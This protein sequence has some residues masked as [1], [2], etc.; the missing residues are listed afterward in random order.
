MPRVPPPSLLPTPCINSCKNPG[1]LSPPSKGTIPPT[2]EEATGTHTEGEGQRASAVPRCVADMTRPHVERGHVGPTWPRTMLALVLGMGVVLWMGAT[3]KNGSVDRQRRTMR[4]EQWNQA[5]AVTQA[6]VR[7]AVLAQQRLGAQGRD[8]WREKTQAKWNPKHRDPKQ[9]NRIHAVAEENTQ[10]AAAS[11]DPAQKTSQ[12]ETQGKER[13]N[14]PEEEQEADMQKFI[15]NVEHPKIMRDC[16]PGSSDPF[17]IHPEE[18]RV[19]LTTSVGG[20][21]CLAIFSGAYIMAIQEEKLGPHFRKSAPMTAAAGLIWMTVATSYKINSPEKI[22][23][24]AAVARHELL[25]FGEVFLFLLVAMT[26]VNTMQEL[27]VFG[28]LRVFLVEKEYSLKTMFWVTGL[29][30][31]FLSPLADNLTTALLMGAVINTVGRG[32]PNFVVLG[33][34]NTVVASNAG[35]AFSPFGDVT[36]LMVWQKHKLDIP[37]FVELLLPSFVSW[38]VPASLMSLTI[39]KGQPLPVTE[40]TRLRKGAVTVTCMFLFTVTLSA[41]VHAFMQLPPVLGMMTGMGMLKM[42]GFFS[43][44]KHKRKLAWSSDENISSMDLGERIDEASGG[45][46]PLDIFKR[47]EKTEWDTLLFFYG[48]IM[49]VGGLGFLGYL[50]VLAGLIYGSLGPTGANMLVGIIS[51]IVDNIPVMYAVLSTDPPMPR[52]EWLLVTLTAGIGGSILSIGS[53]A[54]VGLM[55]QARGVYN[56]RAHL[57]WSWAILLGYLAAVFVHLWL[58]TTF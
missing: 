44:G 40:R 24:V 23:L 4:R 30:S 18:E 58:Q 35:G 21:L 13:K 36:T 11:W 43:S 1:P 50:D 45:Y 17:C 2:V 20:F 34:I 47:M 57:R 33:F 3:W 9:D 51:S 16:E 19:K 26:Y 46:G 25:E 10:T 49:C 48:V 53:A 22:T 28:Y 42:Y 15:Q 56:F 27:N 14:T 7:A 41:L 37:D 12:E 31:F 5:D 6:T 29:I 8:A 38:F 55:G 54:G 52:S 32:H 39:G